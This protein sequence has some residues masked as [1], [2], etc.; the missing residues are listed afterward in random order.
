MALLESLHMG[1]TMLLNKTG[2]WV[3]AG[4]DCAGKT[5]DCWFEAESP[6]SIPPT[7]AAPQDEPFANDDAAPFAF[8][9]KHIHM[10][11]R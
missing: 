3:Y 11:N 8:K 6:C 10:F 7:L 4:P 2:E 5:L 9:R 1:R